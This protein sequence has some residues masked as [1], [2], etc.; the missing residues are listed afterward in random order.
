MKATLSNRCIVFSALAHR[1]AELDGI[2]RLKWSENKHTHTSFD[3]SK[4]ERE[5]K[6]ETENRFISQC[7]VRCWKWHLCLCPPVHVMRQR[8]G[9]VCLGSGVNAFKFTNR[10][11]QFW[12]RRYR[13]ERRKFVFRYPCE[14]DKNT[15]HLFYQAHIPLGS[16]PFR[17][18]R[19]IC[20][21]IFTFFFFWLVRTTHKQRARERESSDRKR[22]HIQ[23]SRKRIILSTKYV[24]SRDNHRYCKR[25]SRRIRRNRIARS[26]QIKFISKKNIIKSSK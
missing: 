3:A 22:I 11:L 2:A 16:I 26:T 9:G 20:F 15:I 25:D 7:D 18:N 19:A 5:S 12:C 4:S 24:K 8:S 23:N 21:I 14:S 6:S 10:Q 1:G 13:F 17:G